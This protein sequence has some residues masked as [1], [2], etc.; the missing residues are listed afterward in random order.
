M[1]KPPL[2]DNTET[3]NI[4]KVLSFLEYDTSYETIRMKTQKK[5]PFLI[6]VIRKDKLILL[7]IELVIH[8]PH[9]IIAEYDFDKHVDLHYFL[10]DLDN[11]KKITIIVTN[12]T[13]YVRKEIEEVLG[14]IPDHFYIAS[15]YN[16][17][18]ILYSVF[19]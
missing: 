9:V 11:Y 19:A 5:I 16:I 8:K 3:M 14:A 17:T 7:P 18:P 13:D 1:T 2:K 10:Q 4:V 6:N 15:K 12:D